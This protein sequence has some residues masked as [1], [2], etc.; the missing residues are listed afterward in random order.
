MK[1]LIFGTT[2]YSAFSGDIAQGR[3]SH[4]Y[5]LHFED[6]KNMRNALKIF[7]LRFFGFS[8]D[9]ADGNRVL[10]ESFPDFKIYP[11][12]GKKFTA[13]CASE[14]LSDCA[15]KPVESDK[16]LVAVCGFEGAAPIIQN[17]MLKTLE[18]PAEGVHFL[19]GATSL[20][21]VL[22]TVKS[23]VKTLTIPPFSEEEI[24][25]ALERK[26]RNSLNRAASESCGGILGIAEG[27]V[28]GGWF[29]EVSSAAEVICTT[30]NIADVGKVALSYGDT[31]YKTE[32]LSAMAA[33]YRKA[34]GE[35]VKG[36]AEGKVA[37]CW[38]APALIYA[39][40]CVDKAARDLKFNAFFQGLLYDLMLRII[41]ENDKWS[42]LQ[43]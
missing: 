1:K 43:G 15:L 7:A 3:L 34:L 36:K 9:S 33:A 29:A 2:A 14:L 32:L 8:A 40:Y 26:E 11:E 42:K 24:F 5:M 13:D 28:G 19:L 31:K 39:G 38:R 23:R 18:E 20:A 10:N 25:S 12:E 17:K 37:S 41:E 16:K 27:M 21:P 4:A 6:A 22:D 35:K 30:T